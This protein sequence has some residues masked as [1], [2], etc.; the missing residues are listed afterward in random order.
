MKKSDSEG[1]V[2]IGQCIVNICDRIN[3]DISN[4]CICKNGYYED[5]KI[6]CK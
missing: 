6:M 1:G 5:D 3:I 2:L 4:K